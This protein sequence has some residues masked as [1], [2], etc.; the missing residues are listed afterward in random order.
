MIS[1]KGVLSLKACNGL[2]RGRIAVKCSERMANILSISEF[3]HLKFDNKIKLR[4]PLT[5]LCVFRGFQV[6]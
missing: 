3:L 6:S 4:G 5:N 1:S 2:F